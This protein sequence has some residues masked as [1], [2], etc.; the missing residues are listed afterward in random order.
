MDDDD[1]IVLN[2]VE[3]IRELN[4]RVKGID[5]MEDLN[6]I[7]VFG[8]EELQSRL[9]LLCHEFR[10]VFSM[11]LNKEPARIKPLT[12]EVDEEVLERVAAMASPEIED[13]AEAGGGAAGLDMDEQ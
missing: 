6:C 8:S 5:A 2:P 7:Q 12:L 3:D 11:K 10:H 9:R 1:E 4:H 13:S